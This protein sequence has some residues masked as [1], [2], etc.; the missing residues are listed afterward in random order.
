MIQS[1]NARSSLAQA[2]LTRLDVLTKAGT[3]IMN[4]LLPLPGQ[5]SHSDLHNFEQLKTI[6]RVYVESICDGHRN[7]EFSAHRDSNFGAP[8][9]KFGTQPLHQDRSS[10]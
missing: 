9:H 4:V 1:L 6:L 2:S 8:G 7:R 10:T 5:L 3:M